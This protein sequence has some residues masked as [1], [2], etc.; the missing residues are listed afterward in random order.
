MK[1]ISLVISALVL[2]SLL[3]GC[4]STDPRLHPNYNPNVVSFG[5]M[6]EFS[7]K[8][9]VI[10]TK[11]TNGNITQQPVM[12]TVTVTDP[13]TG[14]I[15]ITSKPTVVQLNFKDQTMKAPITGMDVFNNFVSFLPSL[16]FGWLAAD[17]A[18]KGISSAAKD[19]LVTTQTNNNPVIIST[20]DGS[21]GTDV[22]Y[23]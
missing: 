3:S 12:E 2:I 15:T 9:P 11:D 4:Q 19:P 5:G 14:K 18:K 1:K 21:Y 22:V 10:T 6:S 8:A 13:T 23:P 7:M 20:S 17:V 16:G